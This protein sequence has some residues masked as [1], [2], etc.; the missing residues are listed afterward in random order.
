MGKTVDKLFI[1]FIY[2]SCLGFIPNIILSFVRNLIYL[3]LFTYILFLLAFKLEKYDK[4]IIIQVGIVIVFCITNFLISYLNNNDIGLSLSLQKQYYFLFFLLLIP[5]L[6]KVRSLDSYLYHFEKAAFLQAIS[7]I[8]LGIIIKIIGAFPVSIAAEIIDSDLRVSLSD[9]MS[10]AGIRVVSRLNPILI[11]GFFYTLI[12]KLNT[13][14]KKTK[15]VVYLIAFYITKSF[16]LYM[17]LIIGIAL[18]ILFKFRIRKSY[19]IHIVSLY[20]FAI[21]FMFINIDALFTGSNKSKSFKLKKQQIE[22]IGDIETH[23]LLLGYG[24]GYKFNNDDRRMDEPIIEVIPVFWLYTSGIIGTI[25]TLY[26]ILYP[27][28]KL[29]LVKSQFYKDRRILFFLCA[30]A[31]IFLTGVSNSYIISG[32][33]AFLVV[34]FFNYYY[35]QE[36]KYRSESNG[37]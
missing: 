35:L 21:V 17:A 11:S 26:L 22:S 9:G 5:S 1:I 14:S 6:I 27:F 16:G 13:K 36:I 34:F 18:F 20:V 25:L 33:T 2:S 12:V 15:L 7:L 23:K 31:A 3:F 28:N 29:R 32:S 19:Y 10:E 30:Q 24:L 37:E 4:G 8:L